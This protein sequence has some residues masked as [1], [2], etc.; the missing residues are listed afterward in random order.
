MS[1][2]SMGNYSRLETNLKNSQHGL[3]QHTMPRPEIREVKAVRD[4]RSRPCMFEA[5]WTSD[6][7]DVLG[8]G[9]ISV[10][11]LTVRL[12]FTSSVTRMAIYPS[13][14]RQNSTMYTLPT[15]LQFNSTRV[16]WDAEYPHYPHSTPTTP[17]PTGPTPTPQSHCVVTVPAEDNQRVPRQGAEGKL[18]PATSDILNFIAAKSSDSCNIV[19]TVTDVNDEAPDRF[20]LNPP[21]ETFTVHE[22][23]L[24]GE[25]VGGEEPFKI[26]AQDDD[27]PGTVNTIITYYVEWVRKV[28]GT[29]NL[30]F[31]TAVNKNETWSDGSIS[32]YCQLMATQDLMWQRGSY[33]IL[34]V[35][36]DSGEPKLSGNKTFDIEILD[37]N[38]NAPEFVFYGCLADGLQIK[39]EENKYEAGS[40]VLCSTEEDVR[41]LQIYV[42]DEDIGEN[43]DFDC[44][45]DY[46]NSTAVAVNGT[47]Q[48]QEFEL[49]RESDQCVLYVNSVIDRESG[50]R[51]NL[52]LHV[53]DKG[54]PPLESWEYLEV[55]VTDAFEAPPY[56]C[57]DGR[58][59][60]TIYMKEN[61]PAVEANFLEG[62]DTDNI[63]FDPNDPGT[64]QEVYYDIVGGSTN[65][66]QL[67]DR[68]KNTIQL[69]NLPQGLD[70]EGM[71]EYQLYIDVTNDPATQPPI[72]EVIARNYTLYLTIKVQDE[73][74]NSPE[75]Q[76]AITIASFTQN[77]EKGKRIAVI[78]A[79]DLDLN[80]TITYDLGKFTWND[81]DGT[82][83][84]EEP[85]KL[86]NGA[87]LILNFK[88]TGLNSGYCTFPIN[89]YDKDGKTNFTTAKVYVITN[90]F[91]LPVVFNN[92]ISMVSEKT[93]DIE[94]IFTSVYQYSC[95][96]D[97]TTTQTSDTG[98]A[99]EGKTV[100]FMHFIDETHNEPVPKDAIIQQTTDVE[101]I[102]ELRRKLSEINLN[103]NSV[104]DEQIVTESNDTL[105]LQVLLGV[106]SLVLGSLV[107]LLLIAYCIRTRSLERQV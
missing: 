64:Y 95:V 31:F 67:G 80:E 18:P 66:F 63:D 52:S 97:S 36:E 84:T 61:D 103:L 107:V 2:S 56:F 92:D 72:S 32:Y 10:R 27:Q 16:N 40:K 7:S 15:I 69:K 70:R 65:F 37:S 30:D 57:L 41:P 45:I 90:A 75:F 55:I 60:Q 88:P 39:M 42:V 87:D 85:F 28:G 98:E 94:E 12:I 3:K 24:E 68:T 29:E 104:G 100:V 77:D 13:L 99:V 54:T 9:E 101:V 43:R 20:D 4:H 76:K 49:R 23:M 44:E 6:C 25:W 58:C 81:T 35:A 83:P 73:N 86:E 19:V 47:D 38:D 26:R 1:H 89:A 51:Y 14:S 48:L 53:R 11:E 5:V 22:D 79:T 93:E 46:K 17:Q 59:T 74:D 50:R 91:Q 105:L 21:A 102:K 62:T 82:A 96:V 71:P 33:E 78:Q 8:R 106:V 34:L